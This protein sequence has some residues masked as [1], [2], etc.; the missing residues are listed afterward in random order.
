MCTIECAN[1]PNNT[2]IK[3]RLKILKKTY[4]FLKNKQLDE[5]CNLL[6]EKIL[7]QI[8]L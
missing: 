2:I 3:L 8:Y 1:Y 6:I 7:Y 5:Y 4:T